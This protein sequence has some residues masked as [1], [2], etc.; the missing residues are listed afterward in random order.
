MDTKVFIFGFGYT[1]EYF[2]KLLVQNNI[3]VQGTSRQFELRK[4][5][6][7]QGIELFDF[8]A[9]EQIANAFQ[10]ITHV[11]ITIAPHKK[12]GDLVRK[13]YITL[14]NEHAPH[15][16]WVGYLSST[17]VYGDHEGGWV[18]EQ[19]SLNAT[20]E[21]NR[22][23]IAAE[24]EWLK[25]GEANH[26]PTHVF[27]LSGI[28][29]PKRNAVERLLKGEAR[30]IYKPNHFFSRI[31]VEDIAQV[32]LAAMDMPQP[33]Q[34]YNVS[35]N[36][37]VPSHEVVQYAAKLL[38]VEA[39]KRINFEEAELSEPAKQFY[40]QNKRVS[41]EKIRKQLKIKLKYPTYREGLESLAAAII[42]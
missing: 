16:K 2:A 29:G 18:D 1:A 22:L 32:L 41:N 9:K 24:E 30:C 36:E 10:T 6:S 21:T 5:Y 27:R 4:K 25:F 12:Q 19:S 35:D 39:P 23:R 33:G 31:H 13:Q 11:L 17:G 20:N 26:L 34:I 15:L 8:N 40:L 38:R 37:P 14:L 7:N 42:N 28:Y 3:S